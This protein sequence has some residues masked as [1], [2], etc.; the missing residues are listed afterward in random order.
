MEETKQQNKDLKI[1]FIFLRHGI[2]C[3]NINKIIDSNKSSPEIQNEQSDAQLTHVGVDFSI[4]IGCLLK[5]ILK[6]SEALHSEYDNIEDIHLIGS[7]PL[8]RS[9]ETAYYIKQKWKNKPIKQYV[10]PYLRE[11]DERIFYNSNLTKYSEPEI[12]NSPAYT[13]KSIVEQKMFLT[14]TNIDINA[15]DFSYV[16]SNK[17]GKEEPG[18]ITK[19][20]DWFYE[21]FKNEIKQK[22]ANTYNVIIITHSGV[23]RDYFKKPVQNN[24]GFMMQVK[25]D[26]N[27]DNKVINKKSI[28]EILELFPDE[29]L[30]NI[31]FGSQHICGI[32]QTRCN[33]TCEIY[34]SENNEPLEQIQIKP[35]CMEIS[36]EGAVKIISG[37]QPE[38]GNTDQI[39]INKWMSLALKK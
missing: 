8:L 9:I 36:Q 15:I 13:M 11:L 18:D 29:I 4:W 38:N 25:V 28:V 6:I 19:F 12:Y 1:N 35:P 24:F 2:A 31:E 26:P 27:N 34:N 14:K 32:G 16:E 39:N 17:I 33:K 30:N 3:H 23:I 20:I 10:F 5:N 37:G 7:S 21:N 22:N